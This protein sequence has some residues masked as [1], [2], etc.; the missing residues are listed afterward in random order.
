MPYDG[1]TFC[2]VEY[3]CF[4]MHIL[5]IKQEKDRSS[6]LKMLTKYE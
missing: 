3:M 2:I 1:V 5:Q 6:Q 4:R